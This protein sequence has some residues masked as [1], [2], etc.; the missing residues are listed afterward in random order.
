LKFGFRIKGK[1]YAEAV[2]EW[3]AEEDIW[4]HETGENA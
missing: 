1:T 2:G 3:G 4:A